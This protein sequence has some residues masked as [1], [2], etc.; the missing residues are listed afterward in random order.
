MYMAYMAADALCCRYSFRQITTTFLE[1][2]VAL[3]QQPL[4]DRI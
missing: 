3:M 4:N 1:I 2:S